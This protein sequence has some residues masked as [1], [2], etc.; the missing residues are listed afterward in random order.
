MW[1]DYELAFANLWFDPAQ[2]LIIERTQVLLCAF[3]ESREMILNSCRSIPQRVDLKTAALDLRYDFRFTSQISHDL[4]A[5][6]SNYKRNQFVVDCRVLDQR[7]ISTKCTLK[8]GER[9]VIF[10]FACFFILH[11]AMLKLARNLQQVSFAF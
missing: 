2:Q 7:A 8:L 10:F 11:P 6:I 4:Y 9:K 5:M 1:H 3:R